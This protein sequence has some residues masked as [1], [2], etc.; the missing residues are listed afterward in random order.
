MGNLKLVWALIIVLASNGCTKLTL[1]NTE[2]DLTQEK[3]TVSDKSIEYRILSQDRLAVFLYKDP[4]AA[5]DGGNAAL[6]QN[7]NPNGILVDA[8]GYLPLPLVGKVKVA[9]LTQTGAAE[10]ITQKYKKYLNTPSVYVEVLNKRI[11]VLGEVSRKGIVKLDRE[12]MT[13]FEAIAHSGDFTNAAMRDE[14][15]IVSYTEKGMQMRTVDLTNFDTL[16]PAEMMLRPNDIVYVKPAGYK[17]F[18]VASAQILS[19]LDPILKA[20]SAYV[21]L[22]NI[23]D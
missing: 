23:T 16:N 13:L 17:Q 5:S 8:S 20:A 22:Q 1:L 7:M 6:G 15:I 21:V 3:V 18:G 9:G 11:L 12:K 14:V 2:K 10:L 19:P 4:Q